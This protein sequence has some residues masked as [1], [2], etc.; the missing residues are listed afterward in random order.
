MNHHQTE[1]IS[2]RSITVGQ[3]DPTASNVEPAEPVGWRIHVFGGAHKNRA[4]VTGLVLVALRKPIA[5]RLVSREGASLHQL[6]GGSVAVVRSDPEHDLF[7]PS[8]ALGIACAHIPESAMPLSLMERFTQNCG[9][10]VSTNRRSCFHIVDTM[11]RFLH[12][13]GIE[14]DFVCKSLLNTVVA[15]ITE[16]G[17]RLQTN[18]REN[19]RIYLTNYS[20]TK[21]DRYINNNIDRKINISEL[22]NLVS[23]SVFHFSRVMKIQTGMAPYEYI[24]NK[25]INLAKDKLH[26]SGK[27]LVEVALECGFAN[28][29]HFTTAFKKATELT[30]GQYRRLVQGDNNSHNNSPIVQNASSGEIYR[31]SRHAMSMRSSL[32]AS[33]NR[34]V[35]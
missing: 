30:P 6:P 16:S 28:Q 24:I 2:L 20:I 33:A 34:A 25:R 27:S 13:L 12:D 9:G 4:S 23:L 35:S 18:L 3:S 19:D 32:S 15:Y 31:K 1:L 8:G 26:R 22:S 14:E 11:L 17:D 10:F 21:I 5:C 7:V 29:S